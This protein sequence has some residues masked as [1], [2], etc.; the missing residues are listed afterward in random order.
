M[1]HK[2]SFATAA[3]ARAAAKLLGHRRCTLC[4]KPYPEHE[5]LIVR[6]PG[7]PQERI[8]SCSNE[9]D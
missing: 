6:R 7:T 3:A 9:Q 5:Y 2:I 8:V 4:G 1:A